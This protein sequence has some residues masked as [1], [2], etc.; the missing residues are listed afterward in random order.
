MPFMN[1]FWATAV[2]GW[3]GAAVLLFL[4]WLDQARTRN[5]TLVDVGWTVALAGCGVFFAL[6]AEG[7]TTQ[8]LLAGT[9]AGLWGVRLAWHLVADRVLGKRPEDA[10]YQNLRAAWG[11]N[12]NAHFAWF[13]QLQALAAAGLS[14]PYLLI[15]RHDAAIAPMQ[16]AGV[17]L[18]ALSI[19]LETLSDRQLAA[20]RAD[21]SNK[22]KTCRAG[23]WRYSRH[24]N[25]FFEWLVWVALALI[26]TPTDDGAWAW[27][28][29]AVMFVLVTKISGI[30]W[31]EMQSIKS[32]GEDYRRYQR[33]TS[34]FVPWFPK[35]A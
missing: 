3:A 35:K 18:W 16:W 28:A 5:A 26:A 7:A 13:Y 8:R 14:L 33:E 19:G 32:R 25:Y 4:L 12:A 31:A 11:K 15:A 23:L 9:L 34:A 1:D 29:P 30:P 27:L 10:R 2:W 22:G 6:A 24:P 21:P 20:F 17:V